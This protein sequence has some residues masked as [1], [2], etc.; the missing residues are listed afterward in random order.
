MLGS[1]F[2][3]AAAALIAAA[4]NAVDVAYWSV[5]AVEENGSPKQYGPGLEGIKSTLE[6]L[7]HEKFELLGKG[8]LG[9]AFGQEASASLT[10]EYRLKIEPQ[11]EEPQGRIR[12]RVLV[13]YD[14]KNGQPP[15]KA[16]DS[17]VVL[18]PDKKVRLGGLK[19]DQGELVLV[20]SAR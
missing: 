2:F 18:T 9:A 20:L 7:P 13:E 1:G 8:S 15:V 17:R 12:I 10:P 14:K 4:S 11:A 16:I 3:I 5:R 19:L 6:D